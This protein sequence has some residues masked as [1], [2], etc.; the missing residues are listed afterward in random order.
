M[1]A[2]KQEKENKMSK[3]NSK[4]TPQ[5]KSPKNENRVALKDESVRGSVFIGNESKSEVITSH[6]ASPPSPIDKKT[7]DTK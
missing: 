7:K 2:I 6:F 5:D 3:N 1:I 4:N